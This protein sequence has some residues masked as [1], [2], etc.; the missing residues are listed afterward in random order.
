M[1]NIKNI[2]EIWK[3]NVIE[4][5]Y[6]EMLENLNQEEIYESFYKNLEFGTAGLRGIMGMGTNRMNIYTIRQTTQ[7]F[8]DYLNNKYKS[9]SVAVA[10]SYDSRNNSFEFAKESARVLAANNIKVY[11]T[12]ELKP[13]PVLSFAVRKLN[14]Q[15]GIM[16]T[17]SHNPP[18]YNGYKCYGED[19]AQI[20][21]SDAKKIYE[22]IEKIDIFKDVKLIE[23]ESGIKSKSI[24]F[25]HEPLY[26]E[27]IKEVMNQSINKDS[28]RNSDLCV[29]YTPLNGAGNKLVKKVI[30]LIGIKN[31]YVVPHNTTGSRMYTLMEKAGLAERI[32]TEI[33]DVTIKDI[34][35]DEVNSRLL[36]EKKDSIDFLINAI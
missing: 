29:V 9:F 24:E 5:K 2:F 12:D 34:N 17:A 32:I 11:I 6:K 16:I 7:G 25:I 1:E 4:K 33:N 27:Y 10:I 21:D 18:E 8:A 22:S 36:K 19:G 23:F 31:F 15:G 35:W 3:N 20:L 13:T 28:C 30:D 14:C 26:D